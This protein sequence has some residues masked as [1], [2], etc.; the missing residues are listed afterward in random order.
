MV[1]MALQGDFDARLRLSCC[2]KARLRWL[3]DRYDDECYRL[4]GQYFSD[5]RMDVIELNHRLTALNHHV[6]SWSRHKLTPFQDKV[7]PDCPWFDYSSEC[8]EVGYHPWAEYVLECL[9]EDEEPYIWF[10]R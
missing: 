10:P 5:R 6:A 8:W 2:Q 7:Y 9:E 3:G 1:L 4:I